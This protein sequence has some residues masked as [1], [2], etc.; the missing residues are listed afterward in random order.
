M[1]AGF[2]RSLLRPLEWLTDGCL[3]FPLGHPLICLICHLFFLKRYFILCV[4]MFACMDVC[5]SGP[6]AQRGQKWALDPSLDSQHLEMVVSHSLG[7][8]N[9]TQVPQK[10]SQCSQLPSHL[11]SAPLLP[12]VGSTRILPFIVKYPLSKDSHSLWYW[13]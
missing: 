10:S 1:S 3:V 11:S 6:G 12:V 4:W 9:Q 8:G 7:A 2:P 13:D 5:H